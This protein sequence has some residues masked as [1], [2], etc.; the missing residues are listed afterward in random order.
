M[1]ALL[2]LLQTERDWP[3]TVLA[4]RLDVSPRTVRRDVEKLRELG[5]RIRATKGPDG[6]YRMGAG[7]QLPPLLFDDDQAI[8]IAVALRNAT[9]SGVDIEEASTRALET[10]RQVMPSRLKHRMDG[11]RFSGA[12]AEPLVEPSILEAVSAA[13]RERKTL[14]FFYRGEDAPRRTHPHAIV[15]R[16]GRLY[17]IGWDVDR[18]DWRIYR[19]DRISPRT[20]HGPTFALRL[21]PGSDAST[22]LAARLKGSYAGNEW[23]CTGEVILN[24]PLR[25]IAPFMGEAT[26]EELTDNSCRVVIGS[27]SW[28]GVLASVARFDAPF[29]IVGPEPLR[30]AARTLAGRLDQALEVPEF[31]SA[32]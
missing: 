3:G 12:E 2:S 28:A 21:L 18:D 8:A 19:L 29:T 6:G 15:A 22:F 5:Y 32:S 11:V 23:P 13:T 26:A 9:S 1:L 24:L 27:W 17:L 10:F 25:K 14:R 20:P 31:T 4:G 7:A 16:F 30:T